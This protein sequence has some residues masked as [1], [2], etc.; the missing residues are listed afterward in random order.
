[1]HLHY[2]FDMKLLRK[3][4]GQSTLT[5]RYQTTIPTSVRKE[6]GLG[7]RDLIEFVQAEDG[8]IL[9]RRAVPEEPVEFPEELI[10]WIQLLDKDQ[11]Q[12]PGQFQVLDEEFFAT[13]KA[14]VG[15]LEV[16]L[17]QDLDDHAK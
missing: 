5:D 17:N 3:L 4:L 2:Y 1:M 10:A 11:Q 14:I 9:L 6:L 7:K 15:D 16:D 12:N 13:A 8:S